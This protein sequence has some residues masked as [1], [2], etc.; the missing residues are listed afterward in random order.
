MLFIIIAAV[1]Y[2]IAILL[3][4]VASR[5]LNTNLSVGIVNLVS[6][7]IPLAV[8]IP[9]MSRKTIADNKFGVM[10]AILGGACIAI[11]GMA[12]AKSYT[13]NKVAI[14]S[15][16]VFGGAILLSTVLS[17]FFLKEKIS[18]M[19]GIGLVVLLAGLA[20]IVYARATGK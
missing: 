2:A 8:A 20:I 18:G 10:I 17:Y 9:I 7:L 14:V 15:P 11:F 1:F 6:A 12:M 19:Q 13:L 3:L 5:H 16:I 4:A